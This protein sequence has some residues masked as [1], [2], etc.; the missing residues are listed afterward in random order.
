MIFGVGIDSVTISVV[1]RFL[2]NPEYA[3][4]IFTDAEEALADEQSDRIDFFAGIYAAKS[5]VWK[6]VDHLIDGKLEKNDIEVLEYED[7]APY[8]NINGNLKKLLKGTGV[9]DF[10]VSITTEGDIASAIVIA[11]GE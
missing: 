7:G 10:R 2:D 3:K 6:S 8:V 1:E 9:T 4:D 11:Q 5:A